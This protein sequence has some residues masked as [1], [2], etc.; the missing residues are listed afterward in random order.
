MRGIHQLAM[1]Q[2]AM[3]EEIVHE[4]DTCPECGEGMVQAHFNP[5]LGY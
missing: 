3:V 5:T 2:D 4:G 1:R